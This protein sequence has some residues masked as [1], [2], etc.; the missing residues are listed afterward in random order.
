[1]VPSLLIVFRETLESA[2]VIGL[3]LGYL[4]RTAQER[5]RSAVWLATAAGI[6][7]SVLGAFAFQWLA[8]GFEGRAEALFE[9]VIMLLGAGLLTTLIVWI[10]TKTDAARRLERRVEARLAAR[11]ASRYAG[12]FL[13][14]FLSILREGVETVLFL[15]AARFRASDLSLLGALI[16]LLSAGLL[17]WAL[18]RGALRI[19]LRAF[20]AAT[21]ALLILFAAGLVGRGIHELQ[22]AGLIPTIVKHLYDL[23]PLLPETRFAGGLARGLFGYNP[24]PSLFEAL[25]YG[26]YL[27]TT[28]SLWLRASRRRRD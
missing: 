20:F 28:G 19:S 12:L 23:N 2:L 6:A 26:L 21:N 16:G 17:G 10:S 22:E 3:V 14:V 7:A 13:L 4:A 8:G 11:K 1:V 25:G 15:T 27:A 18:F 5:L 24:N 9:G